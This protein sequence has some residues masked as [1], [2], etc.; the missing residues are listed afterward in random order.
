MSWFQGFEGS[1]ALTGGRL[2][3]TEVGLR[4]SQGRIAA[5]GPSVVPQSGDRVIPLDGAAL[6]PG[7]VNS[8]VHLELDFVGPRHRGPLRHAREWDEG[9][10]ERHPDIPGLLKRVRYRDRLLWGA[11]RQLVGGVTWVGQ[12][13]PYSRHLSRLPLRVALPYAQA[14]SL[15]QTPAAQLQR[16]HGSRGGGPFFIHLAEGTDHEAANELARLESLGALSARTVAIHGVGLSA[17]DRTRFAAA[18]AGLVVCPTSNLNLLGALPAL[19]GLN[20]LGL[21]T[22]SLLSGA[23]SLLE[24]AQ[25]AHER[26]GVSGERLFGWVTHEGAGLLR[27]PLGAGRL[28]VGAPAHVVAVRTGGATPGAQLL[29]AKRGDIELVVVDGEVAVAGHALLRHAST[30]GLLPVPIDGE[31]RWFAPGVARRLLDLRIREPKL[32]P[33][34]MAG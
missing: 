11:V 6:W 15:T 18:G 17:E 26:M 21:G 30:L 29:G 3:G 12:H 28:E 14:H 32:A 33:L 2:A 31:P 20:R 9:F 10:W 19:D 16:A 1:L 27:L 5:I 25:L 4:I 24:E 13:A 7:L 8:H 22:D 23:E 34:W